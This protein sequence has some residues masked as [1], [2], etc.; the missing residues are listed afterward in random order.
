MDYYGLMPPT[1]RIRRLALTSAL[2]LGTLPAWAQAP[3]SPIPD[4]SPQEMTTAASPDDLSAA[5]S[6]ELFYELLVGEMSAAQGD[7]TNAVAL[8]LEAARESRSEQLYRRA[9][10]L[11]LQSRSGQ[12]ALMVA[13]EWQQNFP[14]SRDANRYSLHTLLAL[15]RVTETEP[16]LTREVAMVAKPAKPST[17][18]AIAQLYSRTTDKVQ[19]AD[20]VA[21]ALQSDT[22]D[23][24]LAP[25]AFA[26]IGH[27]RL[28]AGQKDLALHA[29]EQAY[30]RG[31]TNGATALL[32]L[33]L[34]EARVLGT[35]HMVQ[36]YV[37]V[38]PSPAIHMAYVRVLMGLQRD[39]DAQ[40]Q[41]SQLLEKHP[42][43][44]DAW[45]LQA[46]LQNQHRDWEAAQASLSR[47]YPLAQTVPLIEAREQM[48]AQAYL[49]SGRIALQQ[50][51]YAQAI[52]WLDRIPSSDGLLEVQALKGLALARQGKLAHGRALIRAVP[53][54]SA[55]QELQ[56]RRAE[57]HLL[58]DADAP[59]EAYL[60]QRTLYEQSPTDSNVAYDT[61]ILAERAG[62]MEAMETILRSIIERDPK[63]HHA[64]NAL[65]YSY[66]DRG[67]RLEEARGLI[68]TALSHAPDDP[69][70][71]DSLAWV[72]FRLGN[73]AN[74]LQLLEKAYAQ[75]NDAEIGTH[76]GEVLWT[77]G[78]K[79][80]ARTVWRA[81]LEQDPENETL[82][83][84][85]ERLRVEL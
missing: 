57:V 21:R 34:M 5:L 41:L 20:V 71:T 52:A 28:A 38:E 22:Q 14:E 48:L 61:A 19:A 44:A 76:L 18:L 25:A 75:R 69:F 49:L 68:E 65:G 13:T 37:Q 4:S 63:F 80:R 66:A 33:E 72:E 31:P 17:Y 27:L 24:E 1:L 81:A 40:I 79:Q 15:N 70:I 39:K 45:L 84:T 32:A 10:D 11:A 54:R 62:K 73:H 53:A 67:I 6:A 8:L 36:E 43:M 46:T 47:F 9:A 12:R 58:R 3:A 23:A 26:T 64:H 2:V 42:D 50:K 85:L 83:K 60:L 16:Y 78:H 51:N 77:L 35:E 74:A 59:Q 55:E 29:L 56:K 82:R 30:T 7:L